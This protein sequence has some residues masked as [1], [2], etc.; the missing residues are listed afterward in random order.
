MSRQTIS[1]I[2]FIFSVGLIFPLQVVAQTYPV[3][4]QP[5]NWG[6]YTIGTP[7]PVSYAKPGSAE[8]FPWA[9]GP[10]P[11][12][13][14]VAFYNVPITSNIGAGT[15]GGI[16]IAPW[17]PLS[18]NLM[19]ICYSIDQLSLATVGSVEVEVAT[20]NLSPGSH[21][22]SVFAVAGCDSFYLPYLFSNIVNVQFSIEGTAALDLT[23]GQLS[24]TG[25][26]VS[27]S[28]DGLATIKPGK[29]FTINVPVTAT[30]LN[31]PE[32]RSTT[33]SVQ[34]GSQTITKNVSLSSF[35]EGVTQNIG[36]D[37]TLTAADVGSGKLKISARV[38]PDGALTE[39]S[40]SNNYAETFIHETCSVA[41]SGTTV[42]FFSQ[43]QKSSTNVGW[44]R[45][46]Y[47]HSVQPALKADGSRNPQAGQPVPMSKLGCMTTSLA[48]LFNSY[49]I[50]TTSNGVAMDPGTVNSGLKETNFSAQL[51]AD[52]AQY[53]GYTPSNDVQPNGAVAFA[54]GISYNSCLQRNLT[55]DQC[56]SNSR[57]S[58]SYKG[59]KDTFGDDEVTKVNTEICNGN[60][61]ILKVP[62]MSDSQNPLKSHF[63]IATGMEFD[64]SGTLQYITNNPGLVERFGKDDHRPSTQIRGYRLYRKTDD[65]SMLF[66]HLTSTV[67]MVVTDPTGKR[68]G[69]NPFTKENFAEIPGATFV[70]SES[71]SDPSDLN[72]FTPAETRF[73]GLQPIDGQY[74]V[75][76]Y[77]KSKASYQLTTYHFDSTGTINGV[78]D[79]TSTI[80]AGATKEVIVQH[81]A[82][83]IPV[84]YSSIKIRKAD[85]FDSK[86][87]EMAFIGGTITPADGHAISSVNKFLRIQ[88]GNFSKVIEKKQLLKIKEGGHT[89]YTFLSLGNRGT[90]FELDADTGDFLLYVGNIDLD[91]GQSSI[92]AELN[93]Q[94][95]DV[96]ASNIVT[97]KDIKRKK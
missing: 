5:E 85:F 75:Q 91:N 71:I 26:N 47:A 29:T 55:I 95:D 67:D 34:V 50:T 2:I 66:I 14:Y 78:S 3:F 84:R 81:S 51:G 7:T 37:V 36:V 43:L 39:S 33:I 35:Q 83:A 72:I 24:V 45:D 60:P 17:N 61:V 11:R 44:G 12:D 40:Y 31:N 69:Y 49:G 19:G 68:T 57:A 88:V 89:I 53:N 41:D 94:I 82:Q 77:A 65:P 46:Q 38:N 6:S 56:L 4:I 28:V 54:R 25:T 21:S 23:V 74:K 70:S 20:F 87:S 58:I 96:F 79:Q 42:P 32:N 93:I 86:R 9:G 18:G 64:N 30:A 59:T 97:F 80:N 52:Y 10:I 48:M 15:Y 16:D 22:L 62:S 27:T 13:A 92:S 76:I 1:A 8:R 63:V 90:I 73:E